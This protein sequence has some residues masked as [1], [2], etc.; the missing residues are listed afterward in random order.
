[1]LHIPPATT[2]HYDQLS[3]SPL[4]HT[5][6]FLYPPV[7]YSIMRFILNSALFDVLV[8]HW[9]FLFSIDHYSIELFSASKQTDWALFACHSEWVTVAL[10]STILNIHWWCTYTNEHCLVVTCLWPHEAAAILVHIMCIL[11]IRAP[12]YSVIQNHI[13]NYGGCVF[14]CSLPLALLAEWR[15][16]FS[17][18]LQQHGVECIQK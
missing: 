11:Y 7:T 17:V 14:S 15:G 3:P 12:V 10:H 6:F 13:H 8:H 1:M 18:L 5:Y 16:I 2:Q 4:C 9:M